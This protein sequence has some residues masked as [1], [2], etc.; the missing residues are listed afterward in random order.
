MTKINQSEE[1]PLCCC[2]YISQFGQRSHVL[3]CL[4]DCEALDEC[5]DRL[6]TCRRVSRSTLSRVKLTSMDRLRIPWAGGAKRVDVDVIFAVILLP[7]VLLIACLGWTATLF[8]FLAMPIGLYVIHWHSIKTKRRTKFFAAWTATSFVMLVGVFQLEVVPYLEILF[9]E[10]LLLMTAVAFTCICSSIVRSGPG[11][12]APP[13]T[14]AM[15]QGITVEEIQEPTK[16][17]VCHVVRPARCSHCSICGHCV[18]RR[19]HH[20][21]WLDTC[22]GEKNHRAFVLGLAGLVVSLVYGANLTLTTVCYPKMLWGIILIPES[23]TDVYEDVH[24]ALCYVCGIYALLLAC[25]VA[26]MLLQQLW[27]ISLN[28]TIYDLKKHRIAVYSKGPW[29]NCCAFWLPDT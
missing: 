18:L 29:K 10:N 15:S 3:A 27:L 5:F 21:V 12:P 13:P 28:T 2:E 17:G 8:S 25:P 6:F 19:D 23:C 11:I 1:E 24:I 20:C 16:C 26:L 7:S 4:C 22:V 9:S 14:D